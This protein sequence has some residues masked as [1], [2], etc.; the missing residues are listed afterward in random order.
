MVRILPEILPDW[1]YS[2]FYYM[3]QPSLELA[4]D[5]IIR[6]W[7]SFERARIDTNTLEKSGHSSLDF[8]DDNALLKRR[9]LP[10]FSTGVIT[11]SWLLNHSRLEQSFLY[12]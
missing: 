11:R 4:V 6:E 1:R 8:I 7:V 2:N 5:D 12:D 9:Y 3:I 10:L